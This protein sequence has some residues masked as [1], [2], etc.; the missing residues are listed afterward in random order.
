MGTMLASSISDKPSF[1]IFSLTEP[2]PAEDGDAGGFSAME[3]NC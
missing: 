1:W 3:K 2:G